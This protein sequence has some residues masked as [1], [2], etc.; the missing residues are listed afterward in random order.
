MRA[1]VA[2]LAVAMSLGLIAGEAQARKSRHA[3]YVTAESDFGHGTV[4]GPVRQTRL[5]PQVRL[6]G[7]NWVYCRHS[8]RETLR[9][10]TVDL[11]EFMKGETSDA[12]VFGRRLE[13]R[14]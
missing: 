4:S 13:L 3:G 12:Y 1:L 14:W 6:P 7:G 5:G 11:F 8:C 2:L 9:V 10:Q